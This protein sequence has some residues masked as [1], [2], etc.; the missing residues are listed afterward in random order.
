LLHTFLISAVDLGERLG[1]PLS[2]G[3]ETPVPI[4]YDFR[5]AL[6]P[7]RTL[8]KNFLPLLGSNSWSLTLLA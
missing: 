4:Q 2:M 7:A 1:E 6:E 5:W 8:W 3:K